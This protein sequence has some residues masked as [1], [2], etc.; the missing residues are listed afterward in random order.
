MV[1]LHYCKLVWLQIRQL[2]GSE[3]RMAVIHLF[4]D[5]TVLG[6]LVRILL[7]ALR[8]HVPSEQAAFDSSSLTNNAL[9]QTCSTLD[10][11]L[12]SKGYKRR[13]FIKDLFL[14]WVSAIDVLRGFI[15]MFL[16]LPPGART[17]NCRA[18]PL[19]AVLSLFC[20]AI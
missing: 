20:E 9:F 5:T 4:V 15:Q 12:P 7:N 19:G 14:I 13:H 6:I 17:A 18:L 2:C 16:V 11:L 8:C 3:P 10:T 1:F